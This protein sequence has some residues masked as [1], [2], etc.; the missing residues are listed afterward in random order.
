MIVINAMSK[1][2]VYATCYH[3]KGSRSAEEVCDGMGK[4]VKTLSPAEEVFW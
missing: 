4:N 2:I 1:Y 3:E